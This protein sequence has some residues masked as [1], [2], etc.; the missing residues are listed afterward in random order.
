MKGPPLSARRGWVFDMDGTLTVA[1]HDFAAIRDA[2]GLP[3]DQPILESLAALPPAEARAK[4]A[5]LDRI[6]QELARAAVAAP[7]AAELLA[8]LRAAG[9]RLGVLT[10]N[11]RA[12]A[13]LTLEACGLASSFAPADRVGRD[14][15]PPKPDPE[16]IH[17]LLQR[18]RLT[19]EQAVMVGDF[20][21]DLVAGRA[22]GC[23]TVHVD[24]SGEFPWRDLADRQVRGLDQLLAE[25]GA[26]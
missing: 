2:L 3:A 25:L 8:A 20:R 21:F 23:A 16:G 12:N 19:P 14:D 4:A 15:G 10:R 26:A 5:E 1:V 24:P 9:A 22:A 13:A 17:R 18:W 7:G 6:E 11:S